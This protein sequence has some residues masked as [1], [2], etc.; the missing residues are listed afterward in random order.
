MAATI[1]N[2]AAE[3]QRWELPNVGTRSAASPAAN[4]TPQPT[5]REL[6]ALEQQAREEGFAAGHAE[7][8]AAAQQLLS[9]R[10]AELDALYDA[11]A[12]PLQAFDEQTGQELARL[13]MI[14]AQ[15]VIAQELQLSPALVVQ[16]VRHAADALPAA[17]RELRVHLHPADLTLLRESGVAET[18]WQLL[19]DATLARGDCRLESERSRLDARVETRLAAMIDAVLGDSM[20]LAE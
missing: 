9:Q 19:A 11:A 5:V 7:G 14:V 17:T 8:A 13:A 10:M 12:R 2:V 15:R 6:A 3:F 16:A 1:H 20:G 18:H 4:A